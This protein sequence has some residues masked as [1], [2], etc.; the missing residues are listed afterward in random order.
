MKFVDFLEIV[1]SCNEVNRA[2]GGVV[3]IQD[4]KTP[5]N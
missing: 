3:L 4:M 5:D 1:C 2:E